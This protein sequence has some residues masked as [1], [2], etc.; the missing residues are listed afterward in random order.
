MTHSIFLIIVV[1]KDAPHHAYAER[2]YE[3]YE[4]AVYAALELAGHRVVV[5]EEDEL[6][7]DELRKAE[8]ALC[9]EGLVETGAEWIRIQDCDSN[10]M[11]QAWPRVRRA[12]A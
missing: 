3:E 7:G 12:R 1:P 6:V 5:G 4:D 2:G 11:N 10:D 9:R 8:E